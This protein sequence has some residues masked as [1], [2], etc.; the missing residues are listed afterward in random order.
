MPSLNEKIAQRITDKKPLML[1][2][3][4]KEFGA[5]ELEV[6]KAL[7]K[8][9]RAFAPKESFD[10]VWTELTSWEKATFIMQSKGTVLEIKGT[11]PPGKHGHGYFNLMGESGVGGHLKVDDLAAICFMSMP[12]MGLESHSVQFFNAD[13]EV[14][15]SVYAGREGKVLIPAVCESFLRLKEAAAKEGA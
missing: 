12:F 1:G 9:M 3:M 14:K 4:A 5:T 15:F 6:A 11:I 2:M 7:P 8:E 10:A 13:G